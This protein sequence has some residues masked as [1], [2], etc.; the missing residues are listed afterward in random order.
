MSQRQKNKTAKAD[1]ASFFL[2][3]TAGQK[4]REGRSHYKD[5]GEARSREGSLSPSA[6]LGS[7]SEEQPLT[8]TAM[9]NMLTDLA[10]Q[11]EEAAAKSSGGPPQRHLRHRP[12]HGPR[13][14]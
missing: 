12:T 14:K 5:G 4:R 9:R 1:R 2:T 3:K 7:L 11:H 8:T 13:G 10:E 6:S